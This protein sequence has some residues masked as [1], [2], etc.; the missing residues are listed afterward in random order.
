MEQQ[1]LICQVKIEKYNFDIVRFMTK[2]QRYNM[3]TRLREAN[4]KALKQKGCNAH[5]DG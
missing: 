3:V 5:E 2:P 4:L 1:I